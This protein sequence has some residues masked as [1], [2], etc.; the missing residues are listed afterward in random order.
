MN[1][2]K[3]PYS[4]WIKLAYDR[5]RNLQIMNLS[6]FFPIMAEMVTKPAATLHVK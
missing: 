6:L 4:P 2:H 3:Q 5:L 1:Q